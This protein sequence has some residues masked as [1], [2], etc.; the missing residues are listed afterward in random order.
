[1]TI[2]GSIRPQHIA[3]EYHNAMIIR[4]K[5]P[6]GVGSEKLRTGNK[7]ELKVAWGLGDDAMVGK[8]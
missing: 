4:H 3:T 7:L 6:Q 8:E 2:L 1:M 5:E